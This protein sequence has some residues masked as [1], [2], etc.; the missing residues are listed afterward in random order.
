MIPRKL[1]FYWEGKT[2]PHIDYCIKTIQNR[3]GIE[4]H[5]ITPNNIRDYISGIDLHK[6]WERLKVIS[7]KVDV[8]RVA[9]LFKYGGLYLD[10][11]TVLLKDLNKF[12][13]NIP[14]CDMAV[15][16]W[17]CN[18]KIL[19]G[20]FASP[21]FSNF[22]LNCLKWINKELHSGLTYYPRGQGVF[23]G[24]IM[25]REIAARYPNNIY[26]INS[27]LF[28]PIQFPFNQSVWQNKELVTNYVNDKTLAIGL[29]HS[30]YNNYIRRLPIRH[31]LNTDDLYGDIF[32][33][34]EKIGKIN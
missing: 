25:F 8:L 5:Y 4:F 13:D 24:E 14:N 22:L 29:N 30:Q 7:Q 20:Y 27:E 9:I 34:S 11:D 12:M 33:Y 21:Q 6:N 19:N 16:R 31:I 18:Q 2:Y 3:C 1:F 32:R 26:T 23:F 15:L 28:L 17:Q 10:A